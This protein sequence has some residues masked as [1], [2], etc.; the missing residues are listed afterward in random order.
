MELISKVGG[1]EYF[2]ILEA[3]VVDYF[4]KNPDADKS[5][6]IRFIQWAT[7]PE[8]AKYV[9]SIMQN[10][11]KIIDTVNELYGDYGIDVT[12]DFTRIK[13]IEAA[14]KGYLGKFEQAVELKLIK[15]VRQGLTDK[16]SRKEFTQL[17]KTADDTIINYA[18]TISVTKLMQYGRVSKIEKAR[19]ASIVYF[20]YVGFRRKTTRLFCLNMLDLAADGTRWTLEELDAL[21]NGKKQLK[22]VS[23]YCGGWHCFHDLEPDP[24]YKRK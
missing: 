23:Q 13:N 24:F 22:P 16:L 3:K 15:T 12:R 4:T 7:P 14:T 20:D 6:I 5:A 1:E 17:I 19:T 2:R 9:S 11:N 8:Y 21:D 18:D 10:Y